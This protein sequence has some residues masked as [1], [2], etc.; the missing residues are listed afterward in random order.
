MSEITPGPWTVI[1]A[2]FENVENSDQCWYL[3][4]AKGMKACAGMKALIESAPDLLVALEEG[5]RALRDL[6]M[7]LTLEL[8]KDI[9]KRYPNH[10]GVGAK[11]TAAIAKVRG[12]R[13]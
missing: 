1:A 6:A 12:G 13:S 7:Y 4:E 8:G 2:S 10:A 3:I 9:A 5:E 11:M